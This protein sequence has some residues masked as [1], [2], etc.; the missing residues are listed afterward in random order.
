MNLAFYGGGDADDNLRIDQR[1]LELCSNK[2]ENIQ[3]TY[4]PSCSY[5]ADQDFNDFVKQYQKLKINKILKYQVDHLNSVVVK[6]NILKSDII[7]LGGGNTYYFL[8]H[9]KKSG[10]IEELKQWVN[11]GGILTGLSA[12]G[13]IMTSNIA[14]AGFPTFDKDDNEV[15]IKNLKAMNLVDFEF[16]PHYRNSKRYDEEIL[17]YSSQIKAPVYACTDGAGILFNDGDIAF[18]GR[19]ACFHNGQKF[20]INK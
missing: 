4:I 6:K 19:V 20:F 8:K 10:F 18:I 12:G 15:D 7:H 9:L 16:F 14:T 1:L 3:V 5:F 2:R 17:E 13:I 11:S